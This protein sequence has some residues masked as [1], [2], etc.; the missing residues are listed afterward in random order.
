MVLIV[1]LPIEV[2][3]ILDEAPGL[4]DGYGRLV[5]LSPFDIA[6]LTV[7]ILGVP[8]AVA[9]IRRR[10]IGWGVGVM[11]LLT[12]GA[13]VAALFTPSL[14]A[15]AVILRLAASTVTSFVITDLTPEDRRRLVIVPLLATVGIQAALGITQVVNGGPVGLTT[16]GEREAEYFYEYDGFVAAQGTTIHGYVLAGFSLLAATLGV[17]AA[18]RIGASRAWLA[19]VAISAVPL[20]LTY[21]RMALVGIVLV[22]AVLTWGAVLSPLRYTVPAVVLIAAIVVPSIIALDGWTGRELDEDRQGIDRLTSGRMTLL[23]EAATAIAD[24]PLTGV[25]PGNYVVTIE[26]EYD[27]DIPKEVHSVPVLV[28]AE[29]GLLWGVLVLV[30]LGGLGLA[31]LRAGPAATMLF[32]GF[33]PF[34]A[35]DKFPYSHPNGLVMTALWLAML[36]A[37][38]EEQPDADG[39][40]SR[41][42]ETA[43]AA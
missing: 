15:L 6:L 36:D 43:A 33:L 8:H 9:R 26:T 1:M 27:V 23:R 5:V 19:G 20:G 39:Q 14:R 13:V 38:I 37:L 7:G 35:F 30:A 21:S 31:A 29:N 3:A 22:V 4:A 32:V 17:G 34:W 2:A 10:Q 24:H 11:L 42:Q 25:G 16:W 40:P 28:A 41:D 18:A 12:A